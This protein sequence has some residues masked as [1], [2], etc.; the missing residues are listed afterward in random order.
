MVQNIQKLWCF[1]KKPDKKVADIYKIVHSINVLILQF[2]SVLNFASAK[3]ETLD[4]PFK[5]SLFLAIYLYLNQILKLQSTYVDLVNLQL[6]HQI[7]TE[8][9]SKELVLKASQT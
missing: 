1:Q 7:R 6:A 2:F 8:K 3:T 5:A 9:S 4:G